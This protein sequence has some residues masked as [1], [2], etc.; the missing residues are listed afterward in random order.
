MDLSGY[1]YVCSAGETFD[2]VALTL[3]GHEKYAA[4]ML[5]ANP[6]HCQTT[7]FNGGEALYIPDVY[8][9]SVDAELFMPAD[10]PW[11]E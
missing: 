3:F 11:K 2:S 7:V 8:V 6:E 1:G 5:M 4:E 10:A 9:P